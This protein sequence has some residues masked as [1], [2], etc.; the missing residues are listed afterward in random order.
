M[1]HKPRKGSNPEHII[2]VLR[3]Y[4]AKLMNQT[5]LQVQQ[6]LGSQRSLNQVHILNVSSPNK[7]EEIGKTHQPSH[8]QRRKVLSGQI[9]VIDEVSRNSSVETQSN[10]NLNLHDQ[11][12]IL[13]REM[14]K[15][16]SKFET[17]LKKFGIKKKVR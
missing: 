15:F 3:P 10:S 14:L 13:I 6:P 17:F 9:S 7:S 16:R 2:K 4:E 1:P 8:G 5:E 12:N 11:N